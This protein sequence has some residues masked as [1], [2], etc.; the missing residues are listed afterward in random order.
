MS[1]ETVYIG[2]GSN[3][4]DRLDFCDRA[5]TLLS[6]L[7]H[8]LVTGVSSLYETEPLPENNPGPQWFLNGIVRLETDLTPQSLLEVCREVE[9]S[10]GRDQDHRGGPRTLDLDIL[11]YGTRIINEPGLIV[12]HPRLHLR[13]FV[14]EPL[15]ELAPDLRHPLLNKQVRELLVQLVDRSAV[16]KLDPQ[17]G[18]RYG[19]RPSCSPAAAARDSA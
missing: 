11:L 18:S 4:G 1:R 19:S 2:F 9:Q 12:P 14:L 16:R 10:L 17:P 6:L 8:S 7:P 5:V 3:L 15:A 13:R